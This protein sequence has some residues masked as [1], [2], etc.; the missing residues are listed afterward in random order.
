PQPPV[1]LR[2]QVSYGGKSQMATRWYTTFNIM[3][4]FTESKPRLKGSQTGCDARKIQGWSQQNVHHFP[5]PMVELDPARF[6][7][8]STACQDEESEVCRSPRTEYVGKPGLH[9]ERLTPRQ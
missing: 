2:L 4:F 8:L 3:S 9:P 7:Q 6:L 5:I 1:S